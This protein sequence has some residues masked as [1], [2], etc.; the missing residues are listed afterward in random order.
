[1]RVAHRGVHEAST[2]Q[3]H[4]AREVHTVFVRIVG[5]SSRRQ[6]RDP[7][8][9]SIGWLASC[10]PANPMKF[11]RPGST[12]WDRPQR[13]HAG[14]SR[15]GRWLCRPE[16]PD[17]G[18]VERRPR[19]RDAI[20]E[21]QVREDPQFL[22]SSTRVL[23]RVIVVMNLVGSP[24]RCRQLSGVR[25]E[26]ALPSG[27]RN[28]HPWPLRSRSRRPWAPPATA[29]GWPTSRRFHPSTASSYRQRPYCSQKPLLNQPPLHTVSS[30][31]GSAPRDGSLAPCRSV[32]PS[33]TGH[34]CR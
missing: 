14:I 23:G 3:L 10:W 22:V 1:M 2:L 6:M 27:F 31:L 9:S 28:H 20:P 16:R 18:C 21:T 13:S 29:H 17:G 32:I 30:E 12:F 7:V 25:Q 26:D 4:C 19:R 5:D 33:R 34:A 11:R 8:S 24:T 15:Y